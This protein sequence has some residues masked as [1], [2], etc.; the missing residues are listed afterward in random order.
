VSVCVAVC[1]SVTADSMKCSAS[2]Q[3]SAVVLRA[4]QH[5]QPDACN[6]AVCLCVLRCVAVCCSVLQ[7][8]AVC[9]SVIAVHLAERKVILQCVGWCGS[10]LPCVAVCGSELQCMIVSAQLSAK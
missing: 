4:N 5:T 2:A 7:C 3:M 10:L 9:C 6:V 8:V 1:R